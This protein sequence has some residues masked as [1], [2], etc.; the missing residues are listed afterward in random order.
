M[1]MQVSDGQEA[2][3]SSVTTSHS[4]GSAASPSRVS[5]QSKPRQKAVKKVL[6]VKSV[7]PELGS[8]SEA[9]TSSGDAFVIL[10][11]KFV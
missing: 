1:V 2:A 8:E 7:D 10:V 3:S 11:Q 5:K 6:I 9:R 4:Q